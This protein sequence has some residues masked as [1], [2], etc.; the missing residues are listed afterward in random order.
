MDE[1][2]RI[3]VLRIHAGPDHEADELTTLARR[4][5]R[6]LLELDVAGVDP[7]TTADAPAG[8]KGVD[9]VAGTLVVA[10]GT[11]GLRAVVDL[12]RL[13]SKRNDARS[14]EITVDGDSLKVTGH[15]TDQEKSLIDD[16]FAR[17]DARP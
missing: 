13:W 6:E 10:L 4:L 3:A 12:V 1:A 9:V 7:A 17:R 5:R 11:A 8:A 14:V 2:L 15:S 16:F